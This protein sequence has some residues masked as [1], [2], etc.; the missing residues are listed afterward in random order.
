MTNTNFSQVAAFIW[1]VADLL[2]GDFKQSQYGRVIL[3]F[4]LLRRLECVFESSKTSVLETNEKVKAMPLPE[5]AKEKILLK[6]TKGL[7]F[8]NT[9]ELD[10]SSLGQKNIRANLGNYIQHFSKDAREIFE[11]FK[12][13]EFTGLLDD[14][15]LLYKVIQKFASTDLSPE[16]ISNHDMG[17]V[18]EELIRRF[19]ESSNETAGEHFT[20][21]D[22]VRLTTG[23][24]FSQDDDALNKE[25]VIRTIY[26]PTAGTGGFLSSGTE[27]VYEHNHE[28]VM[29]VFGQELNP[30]S[31]AICKADMLIKGQDVRNIK[32]GNT[33]SNDQLTYE[34]FDYMLSNPPFGVD[35]KKIEDE[36]KDEHEQKGF[37][38]RFGAG[39]PRV[40]DGSLL[41][42]M[43]LISK[44]RDVDSTGQG[45]RIGIILNGSPLFT[46]SAGSGESEI[47]R[48]ILEA[49]LLEAIIA[50]PT[51]MFYNT[52]IATYVWVLS[53]KKDAERKGKVHL[54]NASNLSSKMRKSLGSKRNYL[55]ESEIRTITQNYGAFEAVDTLTLD[56]ES[57]QQ[58]PFSSKIFNS[59]EFGYRRVTIE[60]PLRLSAQLSDDRIAT[61]RFAPKPFNAVMQKVYEN[62]GKD[63]TETSYGQL[64]D[65]AQV[66]IRALIKAEF[67][68]LKE[69]DIKTVL[70]PKLWLEQRALMR[71]A[72]SLQTKIGTAQF[73]DFNIFD[74]LL[75]QAL[76]DGNIK[77]EAKE[78]KQ[79]L[80]AVT[81]K[82]VEAEPV[83]NKVI[84]AQ[85]NP[86]YGQFNYKGKVVEFVQ[87]G[88]LRDAEN[89]A[90]DPSQSTTDLIESYFK[91]EVQPHVADAW[92]NADKRD[93][94][95]GEIGIVGYEIPFNRHF[96]VYEPPRDLAEI[97]ADLDA[98]SREIMALLQEVH[99]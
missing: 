7:S 67:S 77:L 82:N 85:E 87:D 94:Q 4:T 31:Y 97:D 12:F 23:L 16:N 63:W 80:D 90:L 20:P 54:I 91:R 13:D 22:I 72:Q 42:L 14:A 76:K 30:E 92:I 41:F 36:I 2:R 27:Y 56:G 25:G 24:I 37:N 78:K 99:S 28:A 9:S 8:F 40:S 93:A 10:L 6:A 57:E 79:F 49:D 81:W 60:R 55:T 58:K 66:E 1:S 70:E 64:S 71:K 29:R 38:G 18:F 46:G 47:R 83:I 33:L 51:D 74:E 98:V 89:I 15:N 19:A 26:D 59:Y 73:D 61:L 86:L 68:E 39:L 69:K 44:M 96:Y 50:L 32:L 35:W 3:P 43:H 5:E 62:Y 95:D 17:L 11:H 21:R 53:N 88:D 48:Y 65:D 84:K 75:K 52:G 45:S 34:K